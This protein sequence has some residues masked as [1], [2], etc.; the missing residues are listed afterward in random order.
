M[1]RRKISDLVFMS[2]DSV[3]RVDLSGGKPGPDSVSDFPRDTLLPLA[4]Q[5][6]PL[7]QKLGKR[8]TVALFR[9]DAWCQTLDIATAQLSG[10]QPAEADSL[11]GYEAEA[12]SGIPVERS[13][14][15]WV[16]GV[17]NA[18]TTP[19]TILQLPLEELTA[20]TAEFRRHGVTLAGVSH[21]SLLGVA[22]VESPE[23]A[24]AAAKKFLS[25]AT[26]PFVRPPSPPPSS[27]RFLV[28]GLAL[29]VLSGAACFWHHGEMSAALRKAR[30]EN[31]RLA[32]LKGQ[33]AQAQNS[34]KGLKSDLE[35]REREIAKEKG[36]REIMEQAQGGME[37]LL[38]ALAESC[39]DSLVIRSIKS[40][41]P[42][43]LTVAGWCRSARDADAFF[44]ACGK[45]LAE[46]GWTLEPEEV[47]ANGNGAWKFRCALKPPASI[48]GAAKK[49]AGE[50]G[51]F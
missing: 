15:A 45:R 24:L 11:V 28:Y 38:T 29:A 31:S 44:V 42:F 23:E 6:E 13:A 39:P 7:F 37:F 51:E 5:L 4:G 35:E 48:Q 40:G 10:L 3:W 9:N 49:A 41:E 34:L 16:K 33:L 19:C 2:R 14:C 22:G 8:R 18:Q 20:A 1:I 21:P 46:R 43:G 27:G 47:A 26:M 12:F 36:R 32:T 17:P 25:A 50:S 30:N